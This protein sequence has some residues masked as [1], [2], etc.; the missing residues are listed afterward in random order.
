[1]LLEAMH[2]DSR[3][4]N[5]EKILFLTKFMLQKA[6]FFYY[7]F[8]FLGLYNSFHLRKKKI[9]ILSK[10]QKNIMLFLWLAEMSFNINAE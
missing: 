7:V 2:V 1:M 9:N 5:V 3:N 6:L 10:F 8:D 4:R